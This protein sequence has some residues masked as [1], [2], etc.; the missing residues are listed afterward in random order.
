MVTTMEGIRALITRS[1][2]ASHSSSGPISEKSD[3]K[4]MPASRALHTKQSI[5]WRK[6]RRWEAMPMLATTAYTF[7]PYFSAY[8]N[9]CLTMSLSR[10]ISSTMLSASLKIS[11]PFSS[12]SLLIGSMFG[13]LEMEPATSP[14]WLNTA[15]HMPMPSGVTAT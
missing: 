5:D 3:T 14:Y 4:R 10:S 2:R 6:S 1:D 13:R 12:R 8:L 11:S 9:T 15:S 7:L